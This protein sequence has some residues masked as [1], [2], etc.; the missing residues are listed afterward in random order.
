M[1]QKQWF[2]ILSSCVIQFVVGTV[3]Q[4]SSAAKVSRL[5]KQQEEEQ[6]TK[7]KKIQLQKSKGGTVK[8]GKEFVAGMKGGRAARCPTS[9]H[10]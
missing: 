4:V 10:I 1:S 9:T 8:A 5:K 7:H 2:K 3:M 6:E